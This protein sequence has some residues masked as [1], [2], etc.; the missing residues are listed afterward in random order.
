MDGVLLRE[1]GK[2]PQGLCASIAAA[3]WVAGSVWSCLAVVVVVLPK[4]PRL[5]P[6]KIK[7][8]LRESGT[9]MVSSISKSARS[10]LWGASTALR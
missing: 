2:G 9:S 1:L 6:V 10:L 3:F 4:H 8:E 5:V 7:V